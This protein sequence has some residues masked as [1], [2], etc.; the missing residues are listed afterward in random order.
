VEK[1]YRNRLNAH[2]ESLLKTLPEN[3][4]SP[5]GTSASGSKS[6][7]SAEAAD[8]GEKRLSKAEV[9]DMSR[10]YI[11]SLEQKR[12]RL[13]QEREELQQGMARL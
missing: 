10:R 1:Q 9:L 2:F 3:M 12:D 13:E 8:L 4:R 7:G 11:H 5:K 6:D